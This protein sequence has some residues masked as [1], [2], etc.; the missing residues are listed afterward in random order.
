LFIIVIFIVIF[1]LGFINCRIGKLR[2][3]SHAAAAVAPTCRVAATG[4]P[5]GTSASAGG[6]SYIIGTCRWAIA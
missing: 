2:R 5:A 3:T 4:I 6:L 1:R